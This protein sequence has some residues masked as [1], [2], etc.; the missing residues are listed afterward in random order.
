MP[1]AKC[2]LLEPGSSFNSDW[3]RDIIHV[4]MITNAKLSFLIT[5]KCKDISILCQEAAEVVTALDLLDDLVVLVVILY[6]KQYFKRSEDASVLGNQMT[7][8]A[9]RV[10]A[11]SKQM[12]VYRIRKVMVGA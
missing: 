1:V 6:W 9:L 12:L 8:L 3:M 2:N 11:P 10:A 7:T 4:V 5:A